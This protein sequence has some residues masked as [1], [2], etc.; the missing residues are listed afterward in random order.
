MP[1]LAVATFNVVPAVNHT[2]K[3][4]VLGPLALVNRRMWCQRHG[5]RLFETVEERQDRPVCWE[6][7]PVLREALEIHEWVLWADSDAL[8][9]DLDL[10]AESFCD[11]DFDI[12]TGSLAD[13]ARTVGTTPE[14]AARRFPVTTGVFMLKRSAWA[15]DL[16]DRAEAQSQDLPLTHPEPGPQVWD[17][18]GDQEALIKVLAQRPLDL[19]RIKQDGA[20]EAH[21]RF[22]RRGYHLFTHLYGNHANH[23]I[24]ELESEKVLAEWA[25][26]IHQGGPFPGNLATLHWCAIQNTDPAF[27]VTRGGPER[28]LYSPNVG[29]PPI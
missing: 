14:D 20:L 22:F 18:Q 4:D 13:V 21:P 1:D 10:K 8:V 12:I 25:H 11:P 9:L 5:Y 24:S 28:F 17:G 7:F 3:Y 26:A 23:L 2:K 29:V 6:K 19:A 15:M 16:L 27:P